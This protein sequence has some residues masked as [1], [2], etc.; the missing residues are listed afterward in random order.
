MGFQ[1][2]D[3]DRLRDL[4]ETA[5][6]ARGMLG[7]ATNGMVDVMRAAGIE[8]GREPFSKEEMIDIVTRCLVL[9]QSEKTPRKMSVGL[10]AFQAAALALIELSD[11]A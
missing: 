9:L 4:N 7:D 6:E 5:K 10:T 2:M 11:F 8:C 3:P 1:D